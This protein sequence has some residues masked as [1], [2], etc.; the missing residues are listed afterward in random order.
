MGDTVFTSGQLGIDVATGK[1]ASG[2][3]AQAHCSMKNLGA[4]LKAAGLTYADILKTTIFLNDMADFAA[5]NAVYASYF[6]GDYPARSCVQVAALPLGAWW[7][8][9]ASPRADARP[10]PVYPTTSKRNAVCLRSSKSRPSTP[11]FRAS[12]FPR[13]ASPRRRTR[14]VRDPPRQGDSERIPLTVRDYGPRR[15]RSPSF[16]QVVGAG[17]MELDSLRQGDS[18]ADLVGPLGRATET[19]G[20]RKVCV[21]GGGV[22]CAIALPVAKKLHEL[23]AN[24]ARVIGFRTKDL[25]DSGKRVSRRE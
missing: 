21:V 12:S 2:V 23:G 20:V 3:E 24:G 7:K 18:L 17:T 16:F 1:L 6:S 25:V 14:P 10:Y 15:V 9:S 8:S 4:V 19:E 22:G 5:V 11:P 13:P